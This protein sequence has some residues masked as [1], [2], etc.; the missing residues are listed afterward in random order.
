[1]RRI[2]AVSLGIPSVLRSH[3][4]LAS[5]GAQKPEPETLQST[6][7]KDKSS[8]SSNAARLTSANGIMG[9]PIPLRRLASL[10]KAVAKP[11]VSARPVERREFRGGRVLCLSSELLA[12]PVA[13]QVL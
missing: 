10:A 4:L 2:L 5:A 9:G 3:S 6:Q 11:R 7:S 8:Q 1:M 13:R 12:W